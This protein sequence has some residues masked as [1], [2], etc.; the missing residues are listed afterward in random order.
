MAPPR[1]RR[2]L[3]ISSDL[4]LFEP[5]LASGG[6]NSPHHDEDLCGARTV[7]RRMEEVHMHLQRRAVSFEVD[8]PAELEKRQTAYEISTINV[9]GSSVLTTITVGLDAGAATSMRPAETTAAATTNSKATP[10]PTPTDNVR[11]GKT[12][13]VVTAS[14]NSAKS[15][16]CRLIVCVYIS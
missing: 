2:R 4:P 5:V 10:T 1:K 3:S 8:Q 12:V 7:P 11:T 9:N 14:T 6:I 16:M 15:S 13:S